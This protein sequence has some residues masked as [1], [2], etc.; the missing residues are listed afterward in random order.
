[1]KTQN[2]KVYYKKLLLITAFISGV[3]TNLNAQDSL[4]G[5]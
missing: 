3:I 4:M 2:I 5:R 1:M